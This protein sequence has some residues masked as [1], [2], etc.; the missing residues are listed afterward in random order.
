MLAWAF[1]EMAFTN[2]AYNLPFNGLGKKL[3]SL[4]D[5]EVGFW[6]GDSLRQLTIACIAC[7]AC[8]A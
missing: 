8:I 7:I 4:R 2:F 3:L 1:S 5:L 6:G